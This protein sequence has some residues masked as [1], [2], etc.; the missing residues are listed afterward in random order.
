MGKVESG[1]AGEDGGKGLRVGAAPGG[2]PTPMEAP[3]GVAANRAG[4]SPM[5]SSRKEW[6]AVSEHQPIRSPGNEVR[7]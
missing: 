4:S 6:R 7:I 1:S 5:S 2:V 3:A